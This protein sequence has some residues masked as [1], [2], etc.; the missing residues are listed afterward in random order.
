[1]IRVLLKITAVLLLGLISFPA[2]AQSGDTA[3]VEVHWR[4]CSEVPAGE[5]WYGTCHELGAALSDPQDAGREVSLLDTDTAEH[6]TVQLDEAHN[7]YFEVPAGTYELRTVRVE[8]GHNLKGDYLV[9]SIADQHGAPGEQIGQ[10]M[11]VEAGQHIICD[12]YYSTDFESFAAAPTD[13]ESTPAPTEANGETAAAEEPVVEQPAET[14]SL[15]EIE[16][17]ALSITTGTCEAPG[18]EPVAE[19]EP[20]SQGDATAVGSQDAITFVTSY[21]GVP[22]TFETLTGSDHVVLVTSAESG[23]VIACGSIGGVQ[24]SGDSLVFGL[25]ATAGDVTT[26]VATGTTTELVGVVY[27]QP[28]GEETGISV[29]VR[30]DAVQP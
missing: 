2:A 1:M 7:A 26:P 30:Q 9:C 5:D 19:L 12:Y 6:T 25:T 10:P 23:D 17:V 4:P 16:G 28:N 14:G 24:G 11:T 15:I 13:T 22:V 3:L 29:F 27:L 18:A 20:L 8:R 21:T